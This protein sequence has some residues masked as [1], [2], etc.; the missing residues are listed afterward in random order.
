M[1]LNEIK[2]DV[3]LKEFA[4]TKYGYKCDSKG[5]GGCLLHPPDNHNSFSIFQDEAGVWRF[6]CFHDGT[7]GSIIDLKALMEDKLAKEAIRELLQEF[8]SKKNVPY[9]NKKNSKPTSN[10]WKE[11]GMERFHLYMD[12]AGN[13]AFMKIKYVDNPERKKWAIKH[14]SGSEW[15]MGMG[16]LN[17]IP[18][19]L[20]N[21]K[22]FEK[23]IVCEGEKDADTVNSLHT[24]WMATSAPFGKG[25]WDESLNRYFEGKGVVIFL[26]DVGAEGE[27]RKHAG[28][29]KTDFPNMEIRIAKVPLKQY[30]ADITDYLGN[31][32]S[33]EEEDE[34]IEAKRKKLLEIINNSEEFI[35]KKER[36]VFRVETISELLSN[37]IPD[38]EK[39]VDPVVERNGFTLLGGVKGAGKSLFVINLALYYA[40]GKSLFLNCKIQKPGRV[41]LI[42]QEISLS[43]FQSRVR[44][45]MEEEEFS[46]QDRFSHLT[47]TGNNLK[48]TDQEDFDKIRKSI[49]EAK[50]DILILDPLSTFN[51]SKENTYEDMSKITEKINQLKIEFQIGVILTHHISSKQN[52]DHPNTPVE[53]AGQFRG[54]TALP[55]AAD[56]LV[57]LKRLPPRQKNQKL[58]LNYDHYLMLEI[59]LRNGEAPEH[60]AIER[61]EDGLIFRVSNIWQD[62]GKKILPGE[63]YELVISNGGEMLKEEIVEHLK[64]KAHPNTIHKAIELEIE[65]GNLHK[66]PLR[67]KHGKMLIKVVKK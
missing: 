20:E 49:N 50:P 22:N 1:D 46:H 28:N 6:K 25:N 54:H 33:L 47:T 13:P 53:I 36:D 29:L 5:R 9:K 14:Y 10:N 23:I 52:P 21:F 30:E 58:P 63:I 42:Q 19:N 57:L 34:E 55:D 48:L 24:S 2:R 44:K 39:L 18:F 11:P 51:P 38:I 41:L 26:Y 45:I 3:N 43:G 35:E 60:Y 65:R 16:G 61:G 7:S 4:K 64:E 56:I 66:D 67:E 40:S 59:Q 62:I 37:T 15:K 12:H 32:D 31:H 27:A 8:D 17:P